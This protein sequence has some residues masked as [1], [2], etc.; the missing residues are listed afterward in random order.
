MR[1]KEHRLKSYLPM[2]QISDKVQNE[3]S[4]MRLTL[5]QWRIGDDQRT[6]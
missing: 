6:A 5:R 2:G 3:Y 1:Y 4:L